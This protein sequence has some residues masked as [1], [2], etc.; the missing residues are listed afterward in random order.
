MF[1]EF[2]TTFWGQYTLR[3]GGSY[4]EPK[5]ENNKKPNYKVFAFLPYFVKESPWH[6]RKISQ[7]AL[8]YER[9]F[10][11][12]VV[13]REKRGPLVIYDQCN[14]YYNQGV[15]VRFHTLVGT[16]TLELTLEI[17]YDFSICKKQRKL[18]LLITKIH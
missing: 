16:R 2:I 5:N 9:R 10:G 14:C 6:Y 7:K 8:K 12:L 17:E 11:K 4:R 1:Y 18:E 13:G 15:I 3:L